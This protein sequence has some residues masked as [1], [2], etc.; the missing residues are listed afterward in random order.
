M[1]YIFQFL[2]YFLPVAVIYFWLT[3][4]T[5]FDFLT[6]MGVI[7]FHLEGQNAPLTFGTRACALLANLLLLSIVLYAFR[8]LAKLCHYYE[9]EQIFTLETTLI[10]QKLGKCLFYWVAGSV[11][12]NSVMSIIL[13]YHNP[14]GERVFT[15]GFSGSDV[16]AI[17]VGVLVLMISWVMHEGQKV[18]NENNLTI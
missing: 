11:V 17:F 9:A 18:V 13:S 1:H 14:P 12:Y 8:L 2:V 4:E 15:L 10:Y 7:E 3:V 5:P 6:S 16:F